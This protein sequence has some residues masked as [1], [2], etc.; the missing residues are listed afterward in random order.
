MNGTFHFRTKRA[1]LLA[2]LAAGGALAGMAR[3]DDSSMNPFTGESYAAFESGYSRSTVGNPQ[4]ENAPSAWRQ[5]NPD[6]LSERV[7]QSYSAPGEAW[8]LTAPAYSQ[9]AAA[10]QD[11]RRT[12]PNGLDERELQALSSEGS[13]WQLDTVAGT[14]API[15]LGQAATPLSERLAA[16]FHRGDSAAR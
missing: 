8:R 15:T 16:L 2:A 14:E 10:V 4:F 1:L 11:F 9:S 6:G 3:A 7:L 13:A 5:A 12:H